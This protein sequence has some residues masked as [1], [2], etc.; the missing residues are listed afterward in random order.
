[1]ISASVA[2]AV[3]VA[4]A[5]RSAGVHDEVLGPVVANTERSTSNRTAGSSVNTGSSPVKVS[6]STVRN[7]GRECQHMFPARGS[8][9]WDQ[10]TNLTASAK[11]AIV[12]VNCILELGLGFNSNETE[13]YFEDNN[14][15]VAT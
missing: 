4:S 10:F 14:D 6:A 13:G 12:W 5:L 7:K 1:M 2:V 3:I 11:K 15:I 9:S 8:R